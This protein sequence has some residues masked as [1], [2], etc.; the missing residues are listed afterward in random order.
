MQ[1]QQYFFSLIQIR[2]SPRKRPTHGGKSPPAAGLS[3]STLR[4]EDR[5]RTG[6]SS[7]GWSSS[8][9]AT[10]ASF[11]M[12]CTRLSTRLCIRSTA[13]CGDVSSTITTPILFCAH[14]HGEGGKQRYAR[15]VRFHSLLGKNEA[16]S[17]S[18]AMEGHDR[19][20]MRVRDFL[21]AKN[22]ISDVEGSEQTVKTRRKRHEARDMGIESHHSGRPVSA[23]LT[24]SPILG[25]ASHCSTYG[26]R[27]QA[28]AVQ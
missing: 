21:L 7:L 27:A 10:A 4:M 19:H 28:K 12:G 6:S 23:P 22:G 20:E 1:P 2:P 13:P 8:S 5:L 11:L 24:L 18:Q 3:Q 26:S 9:A 25:Y 15:V 14:T 17:F 16:E